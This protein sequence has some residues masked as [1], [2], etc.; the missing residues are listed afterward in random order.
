[1]HIIYLLLIY[2][3]VCII[4]SVHYIYNFNLL[5]FI[6][7]K[8]IIFYIIIFFI[9]KGEYSRSRKDKNIET[10]YSLMLTLI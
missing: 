5:I 8:S 10:F 9:N 4:Y 6:Y 2:I 1:M 7:D 3:I